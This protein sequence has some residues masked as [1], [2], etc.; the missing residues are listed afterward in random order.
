MSSLK[1]APVPIALSFLFACTC[2]ALAQPPVG[3][4]GLRLAN[5]QESG[6]TTWHEH[7][8]SRLT[9]ARIW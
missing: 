7:K 9:R 2:V 4:R 5:A 6:E 1:H 3:G 8:L